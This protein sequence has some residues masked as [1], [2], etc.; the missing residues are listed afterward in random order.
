MAP[1]TRTRA[2]RPQLLP[3][4]A[5]LWRIKG[6][7]AIVQ[8]DNFKEHVQLECGMW[9]SWATLELSAKYDLA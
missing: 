8:E 9:Q 1:K 2:T 5:L 7:S 3:D 6:G 4:H